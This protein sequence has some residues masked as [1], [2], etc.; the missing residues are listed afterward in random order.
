MKREK[1]LV[2]GGSG[3]LG[4][5]VSDSLTQH[6]HDVTIF[7]QNESPYL[8]S[9]QKFIQGSFLDKDKLDD[10]ISKNDYVFHFGGIADI[11]ESSLNPIKTISS[12]VMGTSYILE[13]CEKNNIKKF[14]FSSSI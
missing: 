9:N 2:I 3:F 8:S 5:H 4:S 12:N 14:I 7:D 13:S 10:S 6:G 11:K 1:I